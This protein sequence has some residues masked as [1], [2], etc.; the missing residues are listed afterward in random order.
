M[1]ITLVKCYIVIHSNLSPLD[2]KSPQWVHGYVE[3]ES[4]SEYLMVNFYADFMKKH[5]KMEANVPE[6][7][8]LENDCLYEK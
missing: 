6:Q 5:V 2:Y 1:V 4:G 3:R 8:V 7:R